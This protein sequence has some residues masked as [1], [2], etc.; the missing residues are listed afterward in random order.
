VA[1]ARAADG[2]AI[3][4][5]C[6]ALANE[7]KLVEYVGTEPWPDGTIQ[8]RYAFGHSLFQ[9]AALTRSTSAAVRARHRK[10]GERLEA[11]YAQRVDEVAAEL[12]VHFDRGQ[13]PAKAARY[14]LAAGDRAGQQGLKESCA[15]YERVRAL[16]GALPESR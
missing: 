12:A 14:Y 3:D 2:G 9:H 15:H 7:R 16:V 8:S 10:I 1:H 6:D 4:S 5:S 13:M 11:G